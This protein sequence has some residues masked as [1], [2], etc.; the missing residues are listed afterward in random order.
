MICKSGELFVYLQC[1]LWWYDIYFHMYRVFH[2]HSGPNIPGDWRFS[3][4]FMTYSETLEFVRSC[5]LHFFTFFNVFHFN[6]VRKEKW[7]LKS[8]RSEAPLMSPAF[9]VLQSWWQQYHLMATGGQCC[10]QTGPYWVYRWR[11]NSLLFSIGPKGGGWTRGASVALTAA[12]CA[13]RA[14]GRAAGAPEAGRSV[15][16]CGCSQG[17]H[18]GSGGRHEGR[19]PGSSAA[20]IQ[21]QEERFI[22]SENLNNKT[23]LTLK[24]F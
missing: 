7:K 24:L 13:G 12:F 14:G 22:K 16:G 18:S 11:T 2:P 1:S 10:P 4:A 6:E 23:F 9:L 17:G 3:L 5:R 15:P 8:R 19:D 21:Q 20:L